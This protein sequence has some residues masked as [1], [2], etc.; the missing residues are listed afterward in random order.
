MDSMRRGFTGTNYVRQARNASLG[1]KSGTS[2]LNAVRMR[3]SLASLR[4]LLVVL[5]TEKSRDVDGRTA[6]LLTLIL[7][8]IVRFGSA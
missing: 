2:K 1:P 6:V 4:Y 5:P 8:F 7:F 3:W